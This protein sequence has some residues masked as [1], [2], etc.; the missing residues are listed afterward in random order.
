M[1][2]SML[3]ASVLTLATAAGAHA[4]D[5]SGYK[6]IGHISASDGG[7]DYLTFDSTNHRVLVGRGTGVT[8]IDV[9]NVS[10]KLLAGPNVHEGL[11]VNGG[12]EIL[13]TDGAAGAVHILDGQTGANIAT[14]PTG[15]N[16]DAAAIDPR[17]GLVMV[18]N[19]SGGDVSLIDVKARANVGTITIGGTLEAAVADGAGKAYVNVE[20]KNE[21]VAIDLN[22][23]TVLGHY[24][25]AG[26]TGPTGI[27]MAVP[28]KLLL[29]ACGGAVAVVKSD[30]GVLVKTIKIGNGADGI[31]YDATRHLAFVPAGRD[32]NLS[33]LEVKGQEVNLIDTVPTMVGA[34]TITIDPASGRLYLCASKVGPPP[35]GGG[36]ATTLP[37][38]YEVLVVG[39]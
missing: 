31:V 5:P 15:R 10:S 8:V 22:A 11:S 16:P 24:P 20:D 33:V 37:G 13:T 28:E 9:A 25:M 2:R 12:K 39:K 7:F 3:F 6:V 1:T 18:M 32:G 4:A 34:R 26:C 36:R 35:A 14:I 17:S 21:V 38:S 29:V 19:H 23:K 27:T 30:T